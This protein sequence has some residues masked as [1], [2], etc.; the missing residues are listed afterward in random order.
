MKHPRLK[1]IFL[2]IIQINSLSGEEKAL[3]DYINSFLSALKYEVRADNASKH[4]KSNTDNLIC[5]VGNGGEFIFT[6]HMDTAR[7]TLNVKPRIDDE[8]ITSSGDTVLGVDNRVGVAVLLFTLERIVKEKLKVKDFTVAFTTCEETTLYGSKYLGL[9]NKIKKGFVFDS[10][11]RTGNFIF[12]ACG[13]IGFKVKVIG[14]A[15]HSGI[16]PEKGI[17]S[18]M[19]ASRAISRLPLGRI[20]DETTMNIGLLKGG[21]AVNVIPEMV[22][23]EGEVRSFNL[24]KAERYFDEIIKAFQE[25]TGKLDAKFESNHYWDF[26]PYTIDKN[27]EVYKEIEEAIRKVGLIPLPRVSLGGS[28][29]N[30]LNENGIASVNIGIGAQNPHSNDEFVLLEDLD[31]AA[32]IAY[33]LIKQD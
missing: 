5:Q 27:A 1:Q 12:S 14:K 31:N 15:S 33:E 25:E 9:N 8:K 13:A 20:D 32:D 7:P 3:A 19:A 6:S 21:S 29:A 22:E 4:T 24:M 26:K 17:N 16:S 28:D 30:S 11:F 18:I 2:E 23:L 10:G